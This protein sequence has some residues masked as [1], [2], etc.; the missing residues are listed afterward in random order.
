MT[1][2]LGFVLLI[3]SGIFAGL[4]IGLM[5]LD[6]STLR[7]K[8]K[9]GDV[10]ATK[11]LHIRKDSMILL[12]TL[13]LGNA[14]ANSFFA[15]LVGD[16][17]NGLYAGIISTVLI[18]L[19]GEVFPQAFLSRH[20]L[21]FGAAS[22]PIISLLM[23]LFYP[24]CAP[25]AFVITKLLGEEV[26][27]TYSKKDILSIVEETNPDGG[28]IDTD[29][30]RLVR[31]AL[32]FSQRKVKDVMTPGTVVTAAEADDVID[33]EYL[34]TLKK[35][36]Y[37]RIPVY[38]EDQNYII[39]ILYYKDLV[40]IRLPTTVNDVMD[41]TVNFVNAKDSLDS[42]L[43]QFIKTKMHLFIVIDDF[44]GFEGV[45][46]LEDIIEEIIGAEIMDEEDDV[47]DL[48]Q[49]ALRKKEEMHKLSQKQHPTFSS[50]L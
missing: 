11:V 45:I 42:V 47:A 5:S 43:N 39:G 2:L 21:S 28:E 7:R 18:F 46:T 49:V 35:I 23:K 16:H 26:S 44:G 25:I 1:L 20:A 41:H 36:S 32:S 3:I 19:F 31:G 38:G 9:L 33:A 34:H 13:L 6:L 12:V 22:A 40:G 14:S 50:I 30:Q 29:E 15:I 4:T 24:I 27:Q 17:L 37:S 10:N 48:R 8:S